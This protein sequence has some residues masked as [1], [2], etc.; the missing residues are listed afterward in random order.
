M[1]T[2]EINEKR[3]NEVLEKVRKLMAK[4]ADN[5]AT[6]AE[7]EQAMKMA[8]RLMLQYNIEND[9]IQISSLD[10]AEL[11]LDNTFKSHEYKYWFWD[12]L[13]IIAESYGCKV[14]KSWVPVTGSYYRIIGDKTDRQ[15]IK[16]QFETIYPIIREI[17]KTRYQQRLKDVINELEELSISESYKKILLKENMPSRKMHFRSYYKG[18]LNGLRAKL[19]ADKNEFFKVEASSKAKYELMVVKKE[20]LVEDYIKENMK[21]LK[22]QVTR[23]VEL[24]GDAYWNGHSDGNQKSLNNQL[25]A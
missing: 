24:D 3:R 13:N 2:T 20:E 12:V 22:Q 18:F 15:F 21:K 19:K 8:Q 7:A 6:E 10:I 17:E 5:G 9:D 23:K 11:V 16:N 25:K 4:T 14:I 1:N